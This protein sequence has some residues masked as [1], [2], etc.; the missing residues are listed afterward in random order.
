MVYLKVKDYLFRKCEEDKSHTTK[1]LLNLFVL[2]YEETKKPR[3]C[4][5]NLFGADIKHGVERHRDH[6]PI[7]TVV[8][9]LTD[10]ESPTTG[11]LTVESE[12]PTTTPELIFSLKCGELVIFERLWHSVGESTRSQP[13]CTVNFFY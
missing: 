2:T 11:C 5:I 3:Q 9:A 1:A 4:F 13:R 10:D 8:L 7:C 12:L 6:S